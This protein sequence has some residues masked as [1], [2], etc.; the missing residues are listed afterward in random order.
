MP[1]T[2]GHDGAAVRLLECLE[3]AR[4]GLGRMEFELELLCLRTRQARQ[5]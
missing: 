2:K 5:R 3:N 4:M 1:R